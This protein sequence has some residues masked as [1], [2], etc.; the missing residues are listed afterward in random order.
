MLVCR[1]WPELSTSRE[2]TSLSLPSE[3]KAPVMF[4]RCAVSTSSAG[5]TSFRALV[6]VAF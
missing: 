6:N 2:T 5:G 1:S 3:V 4:G